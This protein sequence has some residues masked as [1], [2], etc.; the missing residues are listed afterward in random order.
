VNRDRVKDEAIL[1]EA[2]NDLFA[3][4]GKPEIAPVNRYVIDGGGSM[5]FLPLQVPHPPRY[6]GEA[7]A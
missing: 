7:D 2:L 1:F 6:K 4:Y 5:T 3:K